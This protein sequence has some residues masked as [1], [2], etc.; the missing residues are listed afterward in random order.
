[1]HLASRNMHTAHFVT[2]TIFRTQS[3]KLITD[4]IKHVSTLSALKAEIKSWIIN[5]CPC[6]LWK[7]F[8][9]DLDFVEVSSSL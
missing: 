8:A 7:I 5:H 6:R 9:K 2:G 1:M 3:V 4:K